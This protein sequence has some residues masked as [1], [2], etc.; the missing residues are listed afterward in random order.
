M[1]VIL[2]KT[3]LRKLR[4][5]SSRSGKCTAKKL[6]CGAPIEGND[7]SMKRN[8]VASSIHFSQANDDLQSLHTK[9]WKNCIIYYTCSAKRFLWLNIHAVY[10]VI[11]CGP[12]DVPLFW[13]NFEENSHSW[14]IHQ[15]NMK[16]NKS[17]FG[18]MCQNCKL[19][20]RKREKF[21]RKKREIQVM[22]LHSSSYYLWITEKG[23]QR[24][25]A[26]S[27]MDYFWSNIFNVT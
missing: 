24:T 19:K 22:L 15:D 3:V 20:R 18:S 4:Q 11:K 8:C 10:D 12:G 7:A 26:W 23:E 6:L 25:N 14:T 2:H 27:V 9:T 13:K 21:S 17:I 16:M 1:V 5:A